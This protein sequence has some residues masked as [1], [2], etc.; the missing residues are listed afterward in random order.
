MAAPRRLHRHRRVPHSTSFPL[1]PHS[2]SPASPTPFNS[3]PLFCYSPP[4]HPSPLTQ[5][6]VLVQHNLTSALNNALTTSLRLYM[7]ASVSP[8]CSLSPS[9][10]T[11]SLPSPSTLPLDP[12][13]APSLSIRILTPI[14][15]LHARAHSSRRRN[16]RQP[17]TAPPEAPPSRPLSP[18]ISA[19]PLNSLRAGRVPLH[20]AC[21]A[22][23]PL[24][25]SMLLYHPR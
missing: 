23:S 8:L 19:P 24:S 16:R 12:A 7:P 15:T 14:T 4:P 1:T 2:P 22:P 9:E 17:S 18:L 21:I 5:T 11:P 25:L 13:P 3:S 10:A 20:C 6:T